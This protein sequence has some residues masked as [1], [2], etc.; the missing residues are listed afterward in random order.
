MRFGCCAKTVASLKCPDPPASGARVVVSISL[1][2][3]K[4]L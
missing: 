4:L 1:E 2:N 3:F